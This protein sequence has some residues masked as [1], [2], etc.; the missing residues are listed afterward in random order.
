MIA[1]M[2]LKGNIMNDKNNI[3]RN[4]YLLLVDYLKKNQSIDFEFNN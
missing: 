2:E 3:L 4:D 1:Y